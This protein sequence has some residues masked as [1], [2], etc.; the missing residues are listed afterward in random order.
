MSHQNLKASQSPFPCGMH[1]LH[2][3][4]RDHKWS[5]V[6]GGQW[7]SDQR[8]SMMGSQGGT[9]PR[10]F[11]SITSKEEINTKGVVKDLTRQL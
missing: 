6:E 8:A 1:S 3:N 4:P 7:T 5:E 2:Q 11:L 10:T 9:C